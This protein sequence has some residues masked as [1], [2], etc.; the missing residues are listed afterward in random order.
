MAAA[1]GAGIVDR[2]S[3]GVRAVDHQAVRHA[4][5]H[6]HLQRVVDR[7]RAVGVV[8]ESLR[9]R[10]RSAL[11]RGFGVQIRRAGKSEQ[12]IEIGAFRA[13]VGE[14]QRNIRG[15][16]ALGAQVP[17]LRVADFIIWIDG[18]GIRHNRARLRGESIGQRE[19]GRRAGFQRLRE[20]EWRLVGHLCGKLM[21]NRFVVE[22][23]VSRAH[24]CAVLAREQFVCRAPGDSDAR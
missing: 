18:H 3:V 19:R 15:H 20:G 14:H 12:H 6:A 2:F 24:G 13:G 16:L 8:G 5:L 23:P 17:N 21:V 10:H 22:N 7:I 11:A 1:D 9:V 4:F